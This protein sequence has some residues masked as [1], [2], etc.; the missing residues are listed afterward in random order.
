MTIRRVAVAIFVL[1]LVAA[2]CAPQQDSPP[3]M[4][5]VPMACVDLQAAECDRAVEILEE[6]RPGDAVSYVT[7]ARRFCHEACP[8]EERGALFVNVTIEFAD[9]RPAAMVAVG[10]DGPV[11]T[12][13][14]LDTAGFLIRVEPASGRVSGPIT[15]L[16]L[17]HCGLNSPI[18]LD[19]SLWDPVGMIDLTHPDLINSVPAMFSLI[20]PLTATLRTAGGAEL[21]VV[22]H[23]GAR[24]YPGCD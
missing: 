13:Q 17:G 1:G 19:G 21:Q 8:G 11:V 16:T 15:D 18:D 3:A 20:S 9:G 5:D 22:R 14:P 12:W 6:H 24:H 23:A 10:E 7:V 2:T 4:A